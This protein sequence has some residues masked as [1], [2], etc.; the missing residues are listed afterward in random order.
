MRAARV[1]VVGDTIAGAEQTADVLRARG[2]ETAASSGETAIAELLASRRPDVVLFDGT[3]EGGGH[4][5]DNIEAFAEA[6]RNTNLWQDLPFII[7]G[8]ESSEMMP[9]DAA[10]L[11]DH[12]SD[13]ALPAELDHRIKAVARLAVMRAEVSLRARTLKR[14]GKTAGFDVSPPAF[15]SDPTILIVG[16]GRG[17]LKIQN[18]YGDGPR[19]L[20]APSTNLALDVLEKQQVDAVVIDATHD[21]ERALDTLATLRRIATWTSLP[22]VA[23]VAEDT[24]A[25]DFHEAGASDVLPVDAEEARLVTRLHLL[26]REHRYARAIQHVFRDATHIPRDPDC[27][28]A[29]REFALKHIVDLV[30]GCDRH[31]DALSLI[32]ISVNGGTGAARVATAFGGALA[33]MVRGEDLGARVGEGFFLLILPGTDENVAERVRDRIS[34]VVGATDFGVTD[35]GEPVVA[36]VAYSLASYR[37][38]DS[39]DSLL[40]RAL[41][42]LS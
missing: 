10:L 26:V 2:F 30:G 7:L 9:G 33:R 13:T 11:V 24:A 16:A 37:P 22:V 27:P 39:A 5:N 29:S 6:V 20:G 42:A 14:M 4:D 12:L 35:S 36:D 3:G 15:V 31:G 41:D 32:A 18:A 34:R 25:G 1:L 28:L 8:D 38:G 17:A 19:F 23:I 40:S 21:G